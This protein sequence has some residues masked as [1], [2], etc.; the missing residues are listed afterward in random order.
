MAMEFRSFKDDA[1]YDV[2]IETEGGNGCGGGGLRLRIKFLGFHDDQD[3]FVDAN[4]FRSVSDVAELR[5]RF[6]SMSAQL[7]DSECSQ[8]NR[9]MIVCAAHSALPDDRRFYDAVVDDV[10]HSKHVFANGEEQ[11]TCTFILSWQHGPFARTLT[12]EALEHICR[13]QPP[14]ADDELNPLLI[15]FLNLVRKRIEATGF[16]DSNVSSAEAAAASNGRNGPPGFPQRRNQAMCK[17]NVRGNE[18]LPG[19]VS[20]SVQ[21]RKIVSG[22]GASEIELIWE[23]ESSGNSLILW[24][25]VGFSIPLS[26]GD[27]FVKN[28]TLL[29]TR[30]SRLS[31]GHV[32]GHD[33]DIGGVPHMIIIDNLEKGLSPSTIMEFIHQQLSISCQAFVSP[34]KLLEIYARGGIL[35]HSKANFD[36]L[37]VFLENPDHIIISSGGRPWFVTEKLPLH[38]SLKAVTETFAL[39][40]QKV[41]QS[42][43]GTCNEL[44]VVVSGTKEYEQAKQLRDLFKQFAKH[45]CMLQQRLVIEEG[46]ILQLSDPV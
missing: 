46:R 32:K 19:R 31:S 26:M 16:S 30:P 15:S 42:R 10:V 8:V 20:D 29:E 27:K 2:R 39:A 3:E 1:W 41:L 36:K 43:T 34:S 13:V 44:K 24:F 17:I 6:R 14:V 22:T 38:G 25:V 35:L 40:S 37:L 11:C 33:V 4:N 12:A 28:L 23:V 5:S 21:N 7:Q 9:G 18:N 45:Q